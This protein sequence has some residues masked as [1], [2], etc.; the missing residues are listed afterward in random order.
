M[1]AEDWS[2]LK[3]YWPHLINLPLL[4][5]AG[6]GKITAILG[7]NVAR[8]ISATCPDITG[9]G[10]DDPVA[11]HTLLGWFVSG[12]T[13]PL[14]PEQ[15]NYF[16]Q[17]TITPATEDPES[18]HFFQLGSFFRVISP[19]AGVITPMVPLNKGK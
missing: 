10:T 19:F 4:P 18:L 13:I 11:R 3:A 5:P 15:F 17:G 9:K 16:H 6:N 12:R 2:I 7:T 14:D 8:L 1:T